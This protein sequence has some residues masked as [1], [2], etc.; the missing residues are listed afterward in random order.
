M[1]L[2]TD[3]HSHTHIRTHS[4]VNN[5]C[6][7]KDN[8]RRIAIVLG[9]RTLTHQRHLHLRDSQIEY[10]VYRQREHGNVQGNIIGLASGTVQRASSHH[11]HLE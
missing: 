10:V 8:F 11:I 7:L 9:R 5:T 3:I 4:D 1:Y 6:Q 2:Y